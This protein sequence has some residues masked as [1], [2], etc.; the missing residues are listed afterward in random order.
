MWTE[1]VGDNMASMEDKRKKTIE[2]LH[3]LTKLLNKVKNKT[4]NAKFINYID[5]LIDQSQFTVTGDKVITKKDLKKVNKLLWKIHK[6]L[7][8]SFWN[9]GKIK[10][11][12]KRINRILG[13]VI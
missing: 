8:H 5:S 7:E 9:H 13:I 1:I 2:N 3:D 12:L 11:K 6:H 4:K 10:R